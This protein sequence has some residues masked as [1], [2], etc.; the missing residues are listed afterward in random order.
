LQSVQRQIVRDFEGR[1]GPAAAR[2]IPAEMA[3][4]AAE[5]YANESA[6]LTRFSGDVDA[7][8]AQLAA[9]YKVDVTLATLRP[10][11]AAG[12]PAPVQAPLR[13]AA[14]VPGV[15]GHMDS[16]RVAYLQD[17]LTAGLFPVVDI[18][19]I[20]P[21][22]DDAMIWHPPV[23]AAVPA[24]MR[25]L[26]PGLA[27]AYAVNCM[28]P[29]GWGHDW[30][31]P[32]ERY[33]YDRVDQDQST[34]NVSFMRELDDSRA[35]DLANQVRQLL[36]LPTTQGPIVIAPLPARIFDDAP[37]PTIPPTDPPSP[38]VYRRVPVLPRITPPAGAGAAFR[39]Q[40]QLYTQHGA[41]FVGAVQQLRNTLLSYTS[42][43]DRFLQRFA[44]DTWYGNIR[45]YRRLIAR[46]MGISKQFVVLS[47]YGLRTIPAWAQEGMYNSVA[48]TAEDQIVRM[49]LRPLANRVVND[50]I[51]TD[52]DGAGAGF[53]DPQI[54]RNALY[55]LYINRATA[56][57]DAIIRPAA[58]AAARE[59]AAEW[60]SRPWPY[61]ITPPETP[62][63]RGRGV[64]K[65]DRQNDFSVVAAARETP[66]SAPRLLLPRVFG[67]DG[68][69][70]V[71]YGQGEAFNWMEFNA[72][73]GRDEVMDQVVPSP[74]GGG[75]V[76]AFVGSPR[77]WRV[78]T[79]GG[80]NWRS[81]LS[82]AD[83]TGAAAQTDVDLQAYLRDGGVATLDSAAMDEL[84]VH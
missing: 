34:L 18:D 59:I 1:V 19:A 82:V 65:A 31:A 17:A 26:Y 72:A 41:A 5:V 35:I 36:N 29:D 58:A 37:D 9:H 50:L 7:Q 20:S 4:H 40:V 33:F 27:P 13:R 57:A 3:A 22:T 21:H 67:G 60:V 54:R 6:M 48:L 52:P 42:L 75:N 10:S 77:A 38:P 81:R 76:Q 70:V 46:G 14:D 25:L 45:S 66:A 30:L 63:D 64:G 11:M 55:G 23:A 51:N 68:T 47:T 84:N 53:L 78:S 28:V 79:A 2:D 83:M 15:S 73:Y 12:A 39:S 56:V 80:W 62:A 24:A 32:M 61:E 8:R 16:I 49:N 44:Q 71:A 43:Y 69:K 74:W